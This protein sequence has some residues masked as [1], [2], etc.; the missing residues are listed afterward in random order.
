MST[1]GRSQPTTAG[2]LQKLHGARDAKLRAK[3]LKTG[4]QQGRQRRDV[5]VAQGIGHIPAAR[6]P[7]G[8][9]RDTGEPHHHKPV[10]PRRGGRGGGEGVD[11]GGR[12][13]GHIGGHI[14]EIVT[15]AA[16]VGRME[17]AKR[18]DRGERHGRQG[19][20]G[21]VV[22]GVRRAAERHERLK[23]E[24]EGDALPQEMNQGPAEGANHIRRQPRG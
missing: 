24:D 11:R 9:E 3:A 23:D 20:E 6:H 10:Q 12:A 7:Q 22:A 19:G 16:G 4:P 13:A 8:Q 17:R 14:L 21:Q 1:T 2:R 18:D 15:D 5:A